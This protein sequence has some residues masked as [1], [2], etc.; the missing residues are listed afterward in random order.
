MHDRCLTLTELIECYL[1]CFRWLSW[2]EFARLLKSNWPTI[3]AAVHLLHHKY[4]F[5]MTVSKTHTVN[6]AGLI[7]VLTDLGVLGQPCTLVFVVPWDIY[8][9]YKH[10]VGSMVPP[11][12]TLPANVNLLVL[13]LPLIH[14]AEPVAST[15]TA[16]PGAVT[17]VKRKVKRRGC[18]ECV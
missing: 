16:T 3:D 9:D 5:Q 13:E 2:Q 8:P 4:L 6:L 12:S 11:G 7:K 18:F 15:S 1:V 17:G 10:H 14:R